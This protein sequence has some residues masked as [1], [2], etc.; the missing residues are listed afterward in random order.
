MSP[1]SSQITGTLKP[2]Y[3]PACWRAVL[4]PPQPLWCKVSVG[5]FLPKCAGTTLRFPWPRCCLSWSA[6]GTFRNH[7]ASQKC[8]GLAGNYSLSASESGR[9][10]FPIPAF[11]L[12]TGSLGRIFPSMPGWQCCRF[13]NFV[14]KITL[15]WHPM[16]A[17]SVKTWLCIQKALCYHE[18]IGLWQELSSID[19]FLT[20]VH[21]KTFT[22][23]VLSGGC[24]GKLQSK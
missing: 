1:L 4:P 7:T 2:A 23:L 21:C 11:G 14:S 3:L 9:P 8:W 17:I 24:W 10:G 5:S 20:E 13:G 22:L 18:E 19:S 15:L 16:Q 6:A 12:L